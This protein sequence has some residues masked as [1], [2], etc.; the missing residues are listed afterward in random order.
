[1]EQDRFEY[2][3]QT[4]EVKNQ[5]PTQLE[6]LAEQ[7]GFIETDELRQIR[8]ATIEASASGREELLRELIEQYQIS[9]EL[10]TGEIQGHA[11]ADTQIGLIIATA[12]LRR[13]CGRIYACLQDLD[14]AVAYAKNMD[15]DL[16]AT[17]LQD[18]IIAL[19]HSLRN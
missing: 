14:D 13:D 17:Q 19:E 9:S 18:I 7:L 16:L 11:Y 10:L 1:M 15:Y 2:P 5:P 8:D 12:T 4:P 6:E 3:P